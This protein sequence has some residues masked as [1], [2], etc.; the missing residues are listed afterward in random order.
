MTR[1]GGKGPTSTVDPGTDVVAATEAWFLRRGLPHFIEGYKATEDVFTRTLPLLTI[2]LVLEA[3]GAADLDWPW[4]QNIAAVGAGLALLVG[5]WAGVNRLRGRRALARPDT[6]GTVELT[7]FVVLPACLPLLF[8]G[9]VR[10]AAATLVGNLALVGAAYLVTSYGIIPMFRWAL[11]QTARQV[12]AVLNL[13]GRALPL[14]LLFGITLFINTE[15]WQVAA[16]LDSVLMAAT[17]VFFLAVGTVFLLLRLPGEVGALRRDLDDADVVAACADSPVAEAAVHVVASGDVAHAALGRRQQGNVLLVLFFSQAV[18]IL[19]VTVT[20]AL[21]FF[22]LGLVAIRP[23]VMATWLGADI[24]SELWATFTLFGRE[25]AITS[26]L[27]HVSA[28]LGTISGFYFT[29]YVITD[30]TYRAEFFTEIV[31]QVRQSI[32]VRDVYLMTRSNRSDG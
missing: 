21:F 28:F 32:A 31:D 16:S 12:G 30:A 8:G 14:L 29:V 19:L 4:W 6:I 11:G 26:A 15:V 10:S 17:V 7:A 20:I 5:A 9:Q 3:M 23:E 24:P 1:R 27:V 2:V 13:L 25:V 18:Q 22:A